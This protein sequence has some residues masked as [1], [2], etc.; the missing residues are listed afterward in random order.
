MIAL[1]IQSRLASE[2]SKSCKITGLDYNPSN[3]FIRADAY[4]SPK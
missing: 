3:E 2:Q 4:R 1:S